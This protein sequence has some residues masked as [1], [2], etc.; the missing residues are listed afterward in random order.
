[1]SSNKTTPPVTQS[2]EAQSSS[3]SGIRKAVCRAQKAM[4]KKGRQYAEVLTRLIHKVTP[5]KQHLKQDGIIAS[6]RARKFLQ[7]ARQSLDSTADKKVV[8]SGPDLKVEIQP[9]V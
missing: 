3:S 5:R 9:W 6:P 4:P 2:S 7:F 1:M 8:S